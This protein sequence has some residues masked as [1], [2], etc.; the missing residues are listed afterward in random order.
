MNRTGNLTGAQHW[1]VADGVKSSMTIPAYTTGSFS[2]GRTEFPNGYEGSCPFP[3]RLDHS[4]PLNVRST[5]DFTGGYDLNKEVMPV[6]TTGQLGTSKYYARLDHVH[7]VKDN[8]NT[9]STM[10][11]TTPYAFNIGSGI[12]TV[13]VAL[14]SNMSTTALGNGNNSDYA[15]WTRGK[16]T[17][18]SANNVCGVSVYVLTEL[19]KDV[20]NKKCSL[21]M[22]RFN[23]DHNGCIESIGE[24]QYGLMFTT[25]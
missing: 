25:L 17:N 22:R 1:L 23:I 8:G 19:R 2:Q 9:K 4:H 6:D 21:F 12:R 5:G 3:A 10:P 7:A 13:E 11:S 15:K 18:T 24:E 20:R 16:K 14:G